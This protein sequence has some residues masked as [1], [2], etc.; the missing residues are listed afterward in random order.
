MS[1]DLCRVAEPEA[2]NACVVHWQAELHKAVGA[3]IVSPPDCTSSYWEIDVAHPRRNIGAGETLI[4]A[5][6]DALARA[7]CAEGE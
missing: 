7:V 6:A 1:Y 3:I 2:H 5:L 4:E